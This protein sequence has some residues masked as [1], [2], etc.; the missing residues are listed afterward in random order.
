ME[1]LSSFEFYFVVVTSVII[2]LLLFLII[3]LEIRMGVIM[4]ELKKISGNA[5]EFLKF[6]LTHFSKRDKK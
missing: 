4:E 5:T 1:I 2:V 3:S 6:G